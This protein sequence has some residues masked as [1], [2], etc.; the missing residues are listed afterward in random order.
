M[1][2]TKLIQ[3]IEDH[4]DSL[5]KSVV[6]QLRT[7]SHLPKLG[8]LPEG[9]L[10]ERCLDILK[11]LGHWLAESDE[12]EIARHFSEVARRRARQQVPLHEVIY[13]LQLLKRRILHYA[14]DQ[15]IDLTTL[16]LYAEEELEHHVGIFFDSVIYQIARAYE[17]ALREAALSAAG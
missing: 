8:T 3:M 12:K 14:R 2:S 6:R 17:Q 4:S 7:D 13:G 11:R 10:R 5:A 15:G 1:L 9:E 16:Q